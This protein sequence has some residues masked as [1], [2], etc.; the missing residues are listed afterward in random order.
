MMKLMNY[1]VDRMWK[2][3]SVFYNKTH[4]HHRMEGLRNKFVLRITGLL[5]DIQTRDF[6]N[7]KQMC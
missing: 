2:E 4:Q 6:P 1:E 7:K 3:K 5:D